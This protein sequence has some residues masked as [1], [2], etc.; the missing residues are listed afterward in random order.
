MNVYFAW[1]DTKNTERIN[2]KIACKNKAFVISKKFRNE[3]ILMNKK[4]TMEVLMNVD[5]YTPI[6]R[7]KEIIFLIF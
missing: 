2:S 4:T 6:K 3:N 5:N 1:T 7:V